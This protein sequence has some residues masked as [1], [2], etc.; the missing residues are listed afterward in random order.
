[1]TG[2]DECDECDLAADDECPD[3]LGR[4]YQCARWPDGTEA[5]PQR[6][7]E[8][9]DERGRVDFAREWAA[10]DAYD[11]LDGA[12]LDAMGAAL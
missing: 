7:C 3:C 11:A 6:P 10:L 1:M 12:A 2:P 8:T 4:G 9:C 5:G